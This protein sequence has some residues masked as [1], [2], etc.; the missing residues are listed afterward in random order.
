MDSVNAMLVFLSKEVNRNKKYT[1]ITP[2][3]GH[4][5]Y[6]CKVQSASKKRSC[7]RVQICL[8]C[9]WMQRPHVL[10]SSFVVLCPIS[11]LN[12][13]S[14]ITVTMNNKFWS[15]HEISYFVRDQERKEPLDQPYW[16]Q[17]CSYINYKR[18]S[19]WDFN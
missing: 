7:L 11:L 2:Q 5:Y 13:T 4:L 15:W 1:C 18:C 3:Q 16:I 9:K 17:V 14:L 6:R 8:C 19:K 10:A 12:L